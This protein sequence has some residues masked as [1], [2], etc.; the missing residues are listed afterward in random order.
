MKL[1]SVYST[2]SASKA[3]DTNK[4]H[5]VYSATFLSDAA[6]DCTI[7]T[8]TATI[9]KGKVEANVTLHVT[10]PGG[11]LRTPPGESVTASLGSGTTKYITMTG[12]SYSSFEGTD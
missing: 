12:C 11:A 4:R 7:A 10:F 3:A 5:T 6:A 1:W 8:S 2:T 9:W